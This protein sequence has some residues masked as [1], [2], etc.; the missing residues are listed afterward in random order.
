MVVRSE[1]EGGLI[2][3]QSSADAI[4]ARMVKHDY[5]RIARDAAVSGEKARGIRS[6]HGHVDVDDECERVALAGV[7]HAHGPSG[8]L[9]RTE[10]HPGIRVGIATVLVEDQIS[11]L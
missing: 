1:E 7:L 6:T 10:I 2:R 9:G 5:A 4:E 11:R 3:L 8:G